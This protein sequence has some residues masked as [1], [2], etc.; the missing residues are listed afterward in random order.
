MKI[1]KMLGQSRRDFT[2]IIKCESCDHEEKLDSGYDDSYYHE[3]VLPNMKCGKCG[4]ST[5]SAN[6][7]VEPQATKYPEGFQI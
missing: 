2:A 7:L 1:L 6:K 4:E 5:I 3:I